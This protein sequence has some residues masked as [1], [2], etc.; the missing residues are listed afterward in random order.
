MEGRGLR[1]ENEHGTRSSILYPQLLIAVGCTLLLFVRLGH[2]ALWDDEAITAMTARAVW[3]TGDTSVRV[4]DHNLLVYRNGLLVR[5]F[6]DRYTPPLQFYLIAPFIG[7]LGDSNFVCRLP[8]AICGLI[9]VGIILSWLRKIQPPPM[10][11]WCA[12]IILLTNAEFFLF[13]RQCRYYGLATMLATAVAYL[14]ITR[15]GSLRRTLALAWVLAALLAAQY[16]DYA[17]VVGCLVVDYALWGRRKP[18][19]FRAWMLIL[20]PQVIVGVVVCS[21]WNPLAQQI[22]QDVYHS[23]SWISDRLAL[24]WWNWRDMIA[25]DFVILPLL[26]A[27]PLLYLKTGSAWLLRAP[28]ALVVFISTIALA[29]PTSLA[30]AHNAEVRYLAPAVPICIAI[31]IVAF[32]GLES[33]MPRLKWIL[34]GLSAASILVEPAPG[35]STPMLGSTALLYY[36]ELAV[37]QTESYTPVIDWIN[38]HV[39]AGAS[40]YVQPAYKAYPLMFRASKAVYAWQLKDPPRADFRDLPPIHFAGRIAPEYMIQFGS[41]SESDGIQQARHQLVLRDIY[42]KQ[43][44]TIHLNWKDLYRPER[45][46]RSFVT[47]PPKDGEEIYIYQRQPD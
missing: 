2:Y 46:W 31:A 21:I 37:P 27:C 29:V 39:P 4:D 7:L 3:Q 28:M 40:I 20:L 23:P 34:L 43:I 9:T 18:L 44:D 41:N 26:L 16:L 6:K 15:D 5:N 35:E 30:Q 25:C 36:H 19:G 32:A 13:F 42:Y 10:V 22:G 33:L 11:W 45:I 1:I 24:L 38:T 17:A 14:Y 8:M 47:V 12:A